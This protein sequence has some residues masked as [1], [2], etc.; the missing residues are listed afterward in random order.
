MPFKYKSTPGPRAQSCLTC[1]QRRRK[2][3]KGRPF[4]QRCLDSNGKFLC[5]GYD[6]ESEPEPEVEVEVESLKRPHTGYIK[7][8]PVGTTPPLRVG[9]EFLDAAPGFGTRTAYFGTPVSAAE[10]NEYLTPSVPLLSPDPIEGSLLIQNQGP[11][12]EQI[13]PRYK[14]NNMSAATQSPA[15]SISRGINNST[16]MRESYGFFIVEEYLSHRFSRFFSPIPISVPDFMMTLMKRYQIMQFLY[17]GAKIFETFNGKPEEAAIQSCSHWVMQYT[18]RVMFPEELSTPYPPMQDAEDR[19]RCL[20]ELLIVQ[21]IVLGTVAGYNSLRLALPSFLRL[22]SDE[23]NLL[24]EQARHGLL[25]VSLPAVLTSNRYETRRFVFHDIMYSLILGLP[26]L[27]EYDSAGFPIVPEN[28]ILVDWIYVVHGVPIEMIQTIAEV[29]GCRTQKKGSDWATLEMRTLAWERS[30]VEIQSE[31][32]VETVHRIAIQ[33]A[34]RHTTLIYIY[35][36]MCEVASDDLRVQT[37]VHQI[38][39]LMRVVGDAHLDAHFSVPSVVAGIAARSESQRAFILR[40][41]KTFNGVRL[42]ILRGG[43]FARVLRYLWNGSA[44]GGAAVGWDEVTWSNGEVV[45]IVF[46][47][48]ITNINKRIR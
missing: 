43:D 37:S 18:G 9:V 23:P 27:A 24:V 4:C 16:S 41:L 1:R 22:V 28:D 13:T 44:A 3:D 36:G 25:C 21:S 8:G 31:E 35:M 30:Q 14:P 11:R 38:I 17:L 26:T 34:W 19:L 42:W 15:F 2:C 32:S 47:N 39:K 33:E 20:T 40:K 45:R 29:H 5:L 12:C 10:I 6:N 7:A 48:M 46:S